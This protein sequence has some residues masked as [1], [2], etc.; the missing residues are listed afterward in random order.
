MAMGSGVLDDVLCARCAGASQA[1]GL[2]QRRDLSF[3]QG[4]QH[5]RPPGLVRLSRVEGR[6]RWHKLW[7][8]AAVSVGLLNTV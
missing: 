6:A 3:T 7:Q 1:V 4:E 2:S 5:S 8:T